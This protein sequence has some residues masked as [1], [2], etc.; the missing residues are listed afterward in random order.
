[1]RKAWA[2]INCIIAIAAVWLMGMGLI[3]SAAEGAAPP[4]YHIL[5]NRA[6]VSYE[7]SLGG[8]EQIET[9]IVEVVVQP[10]ESVRLT[11]DQQLSAYPGTS[12]VFRHYLT[13]TGNVE[14]SYRLNL[15]NQASLDFD[16]QNLQIYLD[17]NG[18]GAINLSDTLIPNGSEIRLAM[19]GIAYILI[20]ATVPATVDP[21]L[22]AAVNLTATSVVQGATATNQDRIVSLPRLELS[23]AKSV[24]TPDPQAGA[25]LSFQLIATNS[26]YLP[27]APMALTVDG[28][29]RSLILVRDKIPSG[30]TFQGLSAITAGVTLY[31]I[32]SNP[33]TVY[34]ATA[35]A[36]SSAIDEVAY[37]VELFPP[38]AFSV[39]LTVMVGATTAIVH[40]SANLCYTDPI[41]RISLQTDSN[42]VQVILPN[43]PIS[44][45]YYFDDLF[46]KVTRVTAL[47]NLLYLEVKAPAF[48]LDPT[49]RE[50]LYISI[51]SDL[52]GDRESFI[53]IE[54]T[55]SSGVFRIGGIQTRDTTAEAGNRIMETRQND[56]LTARVVGNA[57]P[58]AMAVIV[59]D[60]FGTVFNSRTNDPIA[61]AEVTLIDVTG[62]SNG[63]RPGEPAL[64]S[65]S[66]GTTPSANPVTTDASGRFAFPSFEAGTYRMVVTPGNGYSY[67]STLPITSLPSGRSIDP[68]G[69]FGAD[70]TVDSGM[71]TV[72]FDLPVDP[73][74]IAG[75][76]IEKAASATVVEIA[77]FVTYLIKIRNNTGL[78][79]T[80]LR[81]FD[82]LPA[83][84]SYVPGSARLRGGPLGDPAG[85]VGP[86]LVFS[87]TDLAA[88]AEMT[89][90]YRVRVGVNAPQ[91]DC[92]NLAQAKAESALGSVLSNEA[93][94]TVRVRLGLFA[95]E[96]TVI[97]KVF[98]DLNHDC[99]QNYHEPGI[100]G[101]RIVSENGTYA[102]T[103]SEGKYSLYGLNQGV[104]VLKVDATTLPPGAVLANISN[105][106]L[107]DPGSCLVEVKE[108][109]L[110]KVN[111]AEASATAEI[112]AEVEARRARG[113]I[114]GPETERNVS[115]QLTTTPDASVTVSNLRQQPA[116]G[117]MG[118]AAV[119]PVTGD[120]AE[121]RLKAIIFTDNQQAKPLEEIVLELDNQLGFIGLTEGQVL[122]SA[123]LNPR[124]KG[125]LGG[126]LELSV[127]GRIIPETQVGIKCSLT[128]NNVEA[129]EYI[130]VNLNPGPNQLRL[131]QLDLF[132]NQRGEAVI[133]VLAP[134]KLTGITLSGPVSGA[135]ADGKTAI[136]FRVELRD[137][138]ELPVTAPLPLTLEASQGRWLLEDLDPKEPGIQIMVEGG[139]VDLPLEPPSEPVTAKLKVSCG[140]VEAETEIF[141]NP[142][143]R[144]LLVA[145]VIQGSVGQSLEGD[146][147]NDLSLDSRTALYAKGEVVPGY[148]M[149]MSYDSD[150][151]PDT[152]LFR[153]IEPDRGY[154]VYGDSSLK[155][156]DA[157]STSPLYLR[158]ERNKSYLLYGDFSTPA[159]G[160]NSLG[161][162][163]RSFPGLNWH[164]EL[165][166]R[167]L[168][169]F[170]SQNQQT[171]VHD[172][173]PALGVSGPY[174]LSVAPFIAGS[175]IVTI[176]VRDR[177]QPQRVL[178]ATSQ[179]RL[180]D[181]EINA[182]TGQIWFKAPVASYDQN[183]N[184]VF[185]RVD[186]E[187]E[188]GETDSWVAGLN[189][190]VPLNSRVKLGGQLIRETGGNQQ[191]DLR[192]LNLDFQLAANA[193][194]TLEAVQTEDQN[195][196]SGI[197]RRLELNWE[198]SQWQ[199]KLY[200]I[201]T[202]PDFENP[203]ATL[204]GGRLESGLKGSY[205]FNDNYRLN[206]EILN[207]S[208]ELNGTASNGQAMNFEFNLNSNTQME[209]G[210][211][212]WDETQ[213]A[214]GENSN[215]TT[216][217]SR[218]TTQLKQHSELGLFGE[219]ETNLNDFS[220]SIL[221]VGGEYQFAPK[222]KLYLRHELLSTLP[223]SYDENVGKVQNSTLFGIESNYLKDGR[224]FSEYRARDAFSGREAEAAIGLRNQWTVAPGVRLNASVERVSVVAGTG[225]NESTALTGAVEYTPNPIWKWTGRLEL[226]DAAQNQ[227]LFNSLGLAY[228]INPDWTL[229]AKSAFNRTQA[230][231]SSV[232]LEQQ[233]RYQLGA[234]YRPVAFDRFN[235]LFKYEKRLEE[236]RDDS[237]DRWRQVDI[238]GA[239][240]NYQPRKALTIS[241]H[242]A[243]KLVIDHSWGMAADSAAHLLG[244]RISYDLN[245]R[246]DIGATGSI[247]MNEGGSRRESAG[248]EL[249]LTLQKNLRWSLG[250]NFFGY[251][252]QD[253]SR[254]YFTERGLYL[255][256]NYKFDEGLLAPL[257]A[258]K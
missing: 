121:E 251:Q 70:F 57:Q 200:A 17:N 21:N 236:D 53:A 107:G 167:M 144:P 178:S 50:P 55:P 85:G 16:C 64:V 162:Y 108:A 28:Q 148:L 217:R 54:T 248:L 131:V 235:L 161:A 9:N 232:G 2:N 116:S 31:H 135:V 45:F 214:G 94:A 154:P 159:A 111:F 223:D 147:Q 91:G 90:V 112:M 219:Y 194:M 237:D 171:Q 81:L 37:G 79:L 164:Y 5:A 86:Q 18:D 205:R 133:T 141:F 231:G 238:L 82:E 114:Y 97:G 72:R 10:L 76:L 66:D 52:T 252:D 183:L 226:R 104:H 184:P 230:K 87:P 48:N 185:I 158:V 149:T 49:S 193:T 60:P 255:T 216:L 172:E 20:S 256:I 152:Q 33:D 34:T 98:V 221:A 195:L 110:I 51:T 126:R 102:I 6:T 222:T 22:T 182:V 129:W 3:V 186:Y 253:L 155:G 169:F 74:Q 100:P 197:G 65:R 95:T 225:A 40:N 210:L 4:A 63:G 166:A 32:R 247:L 77:D 192:G 234:A 160:Q 105:Q 170:T 177:Y 134:G 29:P 14:T 30:T 137:D 96:A 224:V 41:T 239:D 215:Y 15:S 27:P 19:G 140:V 39:E 188:S 80:N 83:G 73:A 13:N 240:L 88:G 208:D 67:P 138:R 106:F 257:T 254:D 99:I 92:R 228:K 71:G 139:A 206:G 125:I 249:G 212:H 123:Q 136:Q 43:T 207:T 242:Y 36:D 113:E 62:S 165:D 189:W 250:Y 146:S 201:Q 132:G 198:Q 258:P 24:M 44:I 109:G 211:R 75:L 156:F 233:E 196:G 25:T 68:A 78:D 229:L 101:V 127:N 163:N 153:D 117:I 103:D 204:A 84:F 191:F 150:K 11:E 93:S 157:Q 115:R 209:W 151:N 69:S 243:A 56:R 241:T 38:G 118:G 213:S 145:G 7:S 176:I 122:P 218:V 220:Q 119:K 1:M 58:E 180:A 23:L 61:G 179:T 46:Q 130:G 42:Q 174:L 142:Y 8:P 246:F 35:P 168:D 202:D 199:T 173:L 190:R 227:S 59:V 203:S 143:L 12:P 26:G 187:V 120:R 124:V 89:L 181:Y 128:E 47:G 245:S 244:A 175:D